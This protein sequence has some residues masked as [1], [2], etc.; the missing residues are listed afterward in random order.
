MSYSVYFC[1]TM[2]SKVKEACSGGG[3]LMRNKSSMVA[4]AFCDSSDDEVS[5]EFPPFTLI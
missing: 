4:Q 3:T 2:Q 5:D 1:Y